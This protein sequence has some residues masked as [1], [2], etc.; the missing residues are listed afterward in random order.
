VNWINDSAFFGEY[1]PLEQ[2]TEVEM[3]KNYDTAPRA[4]WENRLN[5]QKK[6]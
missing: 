4:R 3:K 1:N 6:R 5:Q 2:A